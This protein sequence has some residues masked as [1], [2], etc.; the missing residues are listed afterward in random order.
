MAVAW[1]CFLA[2]T[3]CQLRDVLAGESIWSGTPVAINKTWARIVTDSNVSAFA[4]G[5]WRSFPRA[6]VSGEQALLQPYSLCEDANGRLFVLD[7]GSR[8]IYVLNGKSQVEATIG[9]TSTATI[10]IPNMGIPG[11]IAL[12][13]RGRLYVVELDW[14]VRAVHI[15]GSDFSYLGSIPVHEGFPNCVAVDSMDRVIIGNFRAGVEGTCYLVYATSPDPHKPVS[16]ETSFEICPP[17]ENCTGRHGF[18]NDIA[19]DSYGRVIVVEGGISPDLI[20]QRAVV[21]DK[22][23]RW[24]FSM[25]S[26]G[27][28]PE[29]FTG[30]CSVALGPSGMFVVPDSTGRI[31]FFLPNG[32][33]AGRIGQW[34]SQPGE[35][36]IIGRVMVTRS[37]SL[38]VP[39]FENGR[40]QEVRLDWN[41]LKPYHEPETKPSPKPGPE[42]SPRML[43][44]PRVI[45]GESFT[46]S[47]EWS[48]YFTEENQTLDW[49]FSIKVF[50]SNGTLVVSRPN[51]HVSFNAARTVNTLSFPMTLSP[52]GT[53]IVVV[54][55]PDNAAVS[56]QLLHVGTPPGQDNHGTRISPLFALLVLL[57]L[58]TI[59][60]LFLRR[61]AKESRS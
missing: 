19:A 48:V 6:D 25:G 20:I 15:L 23:F 50:H 61:L 58:V 55:G 41:S 35:F 9:N 4:T 17:D 45:A 33:Y 54:V 10:R 56:S 59:C 12:D 39:E 43:L 8:E 21:L 29:Q 5:V 11:D 47:V 14:H 44:P 53:Y 37:G 38:L 13:S 31:S 42:P 3:L 1:T 27:K 34:G 57:I 28:G 7:I 51:N 46:I 52:S 30:I 2:L 24:L 60:C 40:I 22:D 16:Y 49:S 36:G 18:P 26:P 32:T